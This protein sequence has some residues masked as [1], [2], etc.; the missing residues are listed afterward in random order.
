MTK[1]K[2]IY[3]CKV[4]GVQIVVPLEA[5]NKHNIQDDDIIGIIIVGRVEKEVSET[6][7]ITEEFDDYR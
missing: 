6:I 2:K 7:K 1:D 4:S 5:R 3:A